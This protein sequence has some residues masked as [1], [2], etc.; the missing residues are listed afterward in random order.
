MI[1]CNKCKNNLGLT[2][3]EL[4]NAHLVICPHCTHLYKVTSKG[5]KAL[6]RISYEVISIFADKR[7][8]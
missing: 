7:R 4:L 3:E 2:N 5:R 6:E 1:K 8:K